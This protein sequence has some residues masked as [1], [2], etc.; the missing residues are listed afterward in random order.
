[1][2]GAG[3]RTHTRNGKTDQAK[4]RIRVLQI[5]VR[6]RKA[7]RAEVSARAQGFHMYICLTVSS[8]SFARPPAPAE[9]PLLLDR[10]PPGP[11]AKLAPGPLGGGEPYLVMAIVA[12]EAVAARLAL[13]A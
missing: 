5:G 9:E 4:N 11:E 7:G 13:T 6:A 1:M 12:N 3:H 8:C 10:G 2:P